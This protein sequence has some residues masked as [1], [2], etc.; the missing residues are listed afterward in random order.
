MSGEQYFVDHKKGEVNELQQQL[1]QKAKM[2]Q[3]QKREVIKKV[4]AYMT[5]GIDVSRLFTDMMMA[6]NTRDLVIK[7]MVYQYLCHYAQTQQ[8]QALLCINSLQKDC[9]D[10][11][12]HVRGLALRS[13]C[14]LSVPSLR[15][16]IEDPLKQGLVD[17]SEYVRK[18]AACGFAKLWRM[19]PD[20][21]NSDPE[22]LD[23]LYN[24]LRDKCCGVVVNVIHSLNEILKDEGG[25]SINKAIINHLLGRFNN[26][27]QWGKCALLEL[28]A[29]YTPET[30]SDIFDIMN[31]MEM[32]MISSNS[33]V[34]LAAVRVFL[35]LTNGRPLLQKQVSARVLAPLITLMGNPRHYI[36][37][38][39]VAHIKMLVDRYPE[40]YAVH[41]QYFFC[42]HN[43][44]PVMKELKVAIMVKLA[45]VH[46]DPHAIITELSEYVGDN[47]EKQ[48]RLAIKAIGKITL[49]LPEKYA[50]GSIDL[51]L[52]FLDCNAPHIT[53][54]TCVCL[55]NILRKFPGRAETVLKRL[56]DVLK[57]VEETKAMVAAFWIMGSYGESIPHAPYML[58]NYIDHLI[59]CGTDMDT[60]VWLEMLTASLRLFF[61]RPPEMQKML[62]R[63]LKAAAKHN[64]VVV[65]DR[66]LLYYR[67]LKANCAQAEKMIRP[68]VGQDVVGDEA[69]LDS[70]IFDEFNSLSVIYGKPAAS[71]VLGEKG[72]EDE[73]TEEEDEKEAINNAE[74]VKES[75]QVASDVPS[76]PLAAQEQDM[77][78]DLLN[79]GTGGPAAT[80]IPAFELLPDPKNL[81][82]AAMFQQCWGQWSVQAHENINTSQSTTGMLSRVVASAQSR[83]LGMIASGPLPT[84][85][86]AYFAAADSDKNIYLIELVGQNNVVQTTIKSTK[87]SKPVMDILK[88]IIVE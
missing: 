38:P 54:E 51:L 40:D 66:A 11:D 73:E 48:S 46:P 50:S 81:C 39:V 37:Y 75:M 68:V 30:E 64:R 28:V 25:M 36:A 23:T 57:T 27:N 34:V 79:F 15:E 8:E 82:D 49:L 10:A 45:V 12:P 56:D 61:K 83:R 58:E 24:M 9:R 76:P 44:P 88:Q 1:R 67:L 84:G 14:G 80:S 31:I 17:Q 65:R 59:D 4:I 42:R 32:Q 18:I 35:K 86:K 60:E 29:K 85:F 62:G 19:E 3:K 77:L 63:L 55:Q 72:D 21:V 78:G 5:L 2:D 26:F 52:R 22:I 16:Y 33:A 7:K 43:D 20:V 71:F 70:N 41:Y 87:D 74:E 47:D 69:K 6:V 13:L 53:N